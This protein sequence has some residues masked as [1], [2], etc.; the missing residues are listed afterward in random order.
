[1]WNGPDGKRLFR[2]TSLRSGA[3]ICPACSARSL[4][5]GLD[6]VRDAMGLIKPAR[7]ERIAGTASFASGVSPRS[8]VSLFAPCLQPGLR[9]T[10][11]CSRASLCASQAFIWMSFAVN[12]AFG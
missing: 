10:A 9:R 2:V 8:F 3:V 11:L 5:A 12:T 4:T 1:M 6:E 7:C